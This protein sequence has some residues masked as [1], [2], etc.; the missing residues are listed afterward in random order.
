MANAAPGAD[1]TQARI[2]DAA[3][4]LLRRHGPDKLSVVD[5]GR[6]LGMSHA[7]V[8]RHFPSK[9]ALR[10]AV[11]ASWL[12]AIAAPLAAIAE[13]R[14]SPAPARLE[15]WILSLA[16]AK[17]AKVRDDPEMFE[18][19]HALAEAHREAVAE[20]LAALRAQAAQ[21]IGDGIADGAFQVRDLEAATTAVMDGM[22]RFHHPVHVRAESDDAAAATAAGHVLKLLLAGLAAGVL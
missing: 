14:A 21:I 7:N 5:V 8:Y 3:T 20:H 15:R 19:Y 16:A 9:A 12:H 4:E 11:A 17:R 10:E 6:A 22:L 13:D 1:A 2:L 18:A